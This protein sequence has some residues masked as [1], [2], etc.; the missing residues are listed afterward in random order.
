MKY[1]FYISLIF[2]LFVGGCECSDGI[3]SNINPE[4]KYVVDNMIFVEG[5]AFY[6]GAQKDNPNDINYDIEAGKDEFPVH[7]VKLNSFYISK[8]EVSQKLWL[9]V[10]GKWNYR[11]GGDSAQ[12]P[13][14]G[15]DDNF[16]GHV[17]DNY[18]MYYATWNDIVG[19]DTA[20]GIAYTA[21]GV[22][23]FKDGF[24]YKLSIVVGGGKRFRLPTEAEWEYAARGGL[25]SKGYKYAGSD[26]YEDVGIIDEYGYHQFIEQ[27]GT[28]IP[29][30]LGLYNM[31]GSV[32]EYCSDWY[33]GYSA[34]SVF[35]PIGEANYIFGER[36]R[37]SRGDR[38]TS[39]YEP[40]PHETFPQAGLR[41]VMF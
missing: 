18:P 4:Y 17:G 33:G 38:V 19:T 6:M 20:N 28:K 36:Y 31:S 1:V 30:E 12:H 34:D 15:Y 2:A 37:I 9:D 24:C 16:G 27:I 8:F 25:N 26:R 35:N 5:G 41:I 29:N 11:Q 40:R 3:T 39:R 14:E 32:Y 23:Y 10:M 13:I 21:N 7:K 22:D